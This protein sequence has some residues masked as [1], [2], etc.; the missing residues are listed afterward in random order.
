MSVNLSVRQFAQANL[1]E[2][3]DAILAETQLAIGSL[4]L[5]ITESAIM[6]NAHTATGILQELKNR[7]IRL[8]IDDFGTGYSSLSYL[9]RFP[10]DTLKIDRSFINRIGNNGENLEIIEAIVTLAHHLDINVVAEGVE[11]KRQLK[12]L[13]V[14]GCEFGQGY[15]FSKPLAA[16][17]VELFLQKV[18]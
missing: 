10:V 14:I 13:K 17:S 15:L 18:A 8:S 7:H 12:T 5:E 2:E 1:I 6:E 11:T 4:N 9:H 16:E 3:I